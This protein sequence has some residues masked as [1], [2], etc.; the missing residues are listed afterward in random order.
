MSES[1][2]EGLN[3]RRNARQNAALGRNTS[4]PVKGENVQEA[5]ELLEKQL[6]QSNPE[7]ANQ[8]SDLLAQNGAYIGD[9]T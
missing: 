3:Q 4:L 9:L 5:M 6:R 1:A 2:Q 7:L 8:L